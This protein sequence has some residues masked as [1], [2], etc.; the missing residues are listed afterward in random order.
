M[1][2]C[3]QVEDNNIDIIRCVMPVGRDRY[4]DLS[5][6]KEVSMLSIQILANEAGRDDT[7][8][9]TGNQGQ[10][11]E[12][13][14]FLAIGINELEIK[15]EGGIANELPVTDIKKIRKESNRKPKELEHKTK[16]VK[17]KK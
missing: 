11:V 16:T 7:L 2:R 13:G 15:D 12:D 8:L 5:L 1:I 10:I 3:Y 14:N 17:N 9:V 6:G 4:V